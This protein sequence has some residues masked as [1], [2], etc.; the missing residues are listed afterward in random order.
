MAN[1]QYYGIATNTGLAL[2]ANAALLG[3]KVNVTQFAVGDANGVPYYPQPEMTALKH[4]VWRG[5]ITEIVQS[6]TSPNMLTIHGLIPA[7]IGGWT[8][9]E[10]GAFDD[11]GN[12]VFLWNCAPFPKVVM[13]SGQ[14]D[15]VYFNLQVALDNA[16]SVN[17]SIDPNVVLATK[18][19]VNNLR[20]EVQGK[21]DAVSTDLQSHVE[22][23]E[24]HLQPG[25]REKWNA[26]SEGGKKPIVISDTQPEDTAQEI[27]GLWLQPVT[28]GDET[29]KDYKVYVKTAADTYTESNLETAASM[30]IYSDSKTAEEKYTELSEAISSV[31]TD[32]SAAEEDITALQESQ[33]TQG[34]DLTE[35]K[36]RAIIAASATGS[37]A[38]ITLDLPDT[39]KAGSLITF[40]APAAAAEGVQIKVGET[41][42]PVLDL[43]REPVKAEAWAADSMVTLVLGDT[44]AFLQGGKGGSTAHIKSVIL[45]TQSWA[46]DETTQLYKQMITIPELEADHKVDFD[47]SPLLLASLEADITPVNQNGTLYAYT[48]EAP[49]SDLS[50][51][52]TLTKVE[53]VS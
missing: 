6:E 17:I 34:T 25:E 24:V 40:K 1:Q 14:S 37:G 49:A 53:V 18:Q 32:L 46:L 10:I 2:L 12:L 30:V 36:S 5:N 13:E 22:N 33:S 48:S 31:E 26:A 47:I 15:D 11:S 9:A 23:T 8:I 50:V 41:A 51:Q 42:Y 45:R 39:P 21:I 44:N 28:S 4:E 38:E 16:S 29:E 35:V 52:A 43:D 7:N 19:D 3:N 20:I 27:N